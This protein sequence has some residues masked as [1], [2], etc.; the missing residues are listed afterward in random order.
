MKLSSKILTASLLPFLAIVGMYHLLSSSAFS[1]HLGDTFHQQADNQLNRAESEI[2]FF[3]INNESHLYLLGAIS[4]PDQQKPDATRL[5]LRGLLQNVVNFFQI[6]AINRTG[7]EWLRINKFPTGRE[8][9]ESLNL[10]SSPVYQY[11]MLELSTY[12]GEI[13]WEKDYPLPFQDIAVPFKDR[14]NRQ[15]AGII[16]ARLSFQGIQDLLEHYLPARGKIMLVRPDTSEV[17]AQADDTRT[18]YRSQEQEVLGVLKQTSKEH[19]WLKMDQNGHG[20]TFIYRKFIIND[21]A[22]LLLYYQPNDTIYFLTN[23]L[24]IYNSILTLAGLAF[25]LLTSFFLIKLITTPLTTLSKRI[26]SLSRL[27]QSGDEIDKPFPNEKTGDEVAQ[28]DAVITHYQQQIS[29]YNRDIEN[30]NKTLQE[31]VVERRHAQEALAAEKERLA[32]TLKS[33]GDGVITTDTHGKIVLINMVAEKLT[34]WSQKE[35]VSRSLNDVFHIRDMKHGQRLTNTV[36][37]ILTAGTSPSASDPKVLLAKDGRERTITDSGAIIQGTDGKMI[38]VVLVFRDM[39]EKV[40]MEEELLKT[41]KLESIGVLAGGIAHDFNN[42]LTAVIGNINLA[43]ELVASE[44]QAY[45][46]LLEAEKASLLAK[47]LT[48]QLLTF[49]KGGEPVRKVAKIDEVVRDSTSFIIRG[50][51]ISC[52]YEFSATLWPVEIDT[53]QMSQV[54]QN[55][56]LNARQ[57]MA[58]GGV[59][60]I[61]FENFSKDDSHLIPLRSG[62]YIKIAITDKGSGIPSNLIDKIFDPY[63]TTKETGSGLGLAT[64]YSI[65][66]KHNGHISAESV[67]GQGTTFTL[68]IPASPRKELIVKTE[69]PDRLKEVSGKGRILFMDDEE[70]VGEVARKMLSFLGYEICLALDGTEALEIYRKN[71][72]ENNPFDLV[73]MDLTIPGGMGGQEAV[74]QIL[75]ID[76]DAKVLVSSGYSNDPVMSS[77]EKYGFIGIINKPFQLSD[78]SEAISLALPHSHSHN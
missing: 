37:D 29:T 56:I 62:D 9:T 2:R 77:Y 40:Q 55:I 52:D 61:T 59:I 28:L 24:E 64:T 53:G 26:S 36:A 21:R 68:Y 33:I 72:V 74:T 54:I 4:P 75:K 66:N 10:F 7:S 8:K 11:P 39:T 13:T 23:R 19:G 45:K 58:N 12:F 20:A 49:S 63:F 65:I 22:F 27:Y 42:I 70:M 48:Q 6:S 47:N 14:S 3:F 41:R 30:V 25:F 69:V 5:A 38:G 1:D 60:T 71:Q 17:L 73:I 57:A 16:R 46:L 43:T 76:P 78:M 67:Q 44:D 32:V 50:S 15:V 31:E 18:D 34:G 51:N 35:A